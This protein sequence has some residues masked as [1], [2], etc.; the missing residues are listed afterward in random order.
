MHDEF[1]ES[2][3]LPQPVSVPTQLSCV[4]FNLRVDGTMDI[5]TFFQDGR[6]VRQEQDTDADGRVDTKIY[7]ERGRMVRTE[8][9]LAGRSSP[10]QWHPDRWE[11]F[12]DGRMV[13]MGTDVDGD[14]NVDRWDRDHEWNER[15]REEDNQQSVDDAVA[16]TPDPEG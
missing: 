14:G 12:E 2:G 4:L 10:S 3:G 7:F 9:D 16:D 13:R 6:V 5:I 1:R 15:R 11:Y 8:R